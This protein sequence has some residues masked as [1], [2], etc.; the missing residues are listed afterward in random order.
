[1]RISSPSS[2]SLTEPRRHPSASTLQRFRPGISRSPSGSSSRFTTDTQNPTIIILTL[3][4]AVCLPALAAIR[5]NIPNILTRSSFGFFQRFPAGD[6]IWK[7]ERRE[8]EVRRYVVP[9]RENEFGRDANQRRRAVGGPVLVV[10]TADRWTAV[11]IKRQLT[12]RPQRIGS[13]RK[14]DPRARANQ[15]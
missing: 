7:E 2:S 12:G 13:C 1:M 4:K 11:E 6:R 9:S 5:F 10:R 14:L 15:R 8:R 3:A